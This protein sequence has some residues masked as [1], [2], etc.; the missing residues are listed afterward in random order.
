MISDFGLIIAIILMT[1]LTHII[2]F[3]VPIL[4]VP[5]SLRVIIFFLFIFFS[6]K[7]FI[8]LFN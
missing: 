3:E 5:T 8:Y 2:Q 7:K 1:I 4:K 6:I